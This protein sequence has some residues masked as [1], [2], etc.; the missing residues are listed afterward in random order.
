MGLDRFGFFAIVVATR[1]F[2][3]DLVYYFRVGESG[4]VTGFDLLFSFALFGVGHLVGLWVGVA[5]LVGALI[6]W[7]WGVPHFIGTLARSDARAGR[8]GP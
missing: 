8:A 5:M 4:G 2:A 1:I 3:S 6:A 7:G